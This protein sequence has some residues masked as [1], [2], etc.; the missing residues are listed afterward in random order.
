MRYN[1][2]IELLE[3]GQTVFGCFPLDNDE[4]I[5][6]IARSDY[7]FVMIE[8]EHTGFDGHRISRA[9]QAYSIAAC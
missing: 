5:A 6:T 4:E 9:L 1:E 3:S 8:T 2:V 7:D